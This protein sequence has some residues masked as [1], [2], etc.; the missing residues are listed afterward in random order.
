M[1]ADI[2][3]PRNEVFT[4]E[5]LTLF[6]QIVAEHA[7]VEEGH[8]FGFSDQAYHLRLAKTV[9]RVSRIA[10]RGAQPV[11]SFSYRFGPRSIG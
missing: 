9:K 2:A 8:A 4:L 7:E 1:G 10:A 11:P 6:L 3:R 5:E